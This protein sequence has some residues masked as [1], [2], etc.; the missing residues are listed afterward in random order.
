[1]AHCRVVPAAGGPAQEV[2]LQM[3]VEA[4]AGFTSWIEA[5]PSR[6]GTII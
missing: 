2:R 6:V 5:T 4:Y 3:S 1:M